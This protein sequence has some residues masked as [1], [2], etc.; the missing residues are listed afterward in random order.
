MSHVKTISF[1]PVIDNNTNR[2]A[3]EEYAAHHSDHLK[4]TSLLKRENNHSWIVSDGIFQYQNGKK[5]YDPENTSSSQYPNI[6]NPIWQVNP[7]GKNQER[8]IMM[9]RHTSS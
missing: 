7:L 5:I 6:L 3:W 1:A 4:S 9:N 8:L 2:L